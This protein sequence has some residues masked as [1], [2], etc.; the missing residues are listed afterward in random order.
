[1]FRGGGGGAAPLFCGC[2]FVCWG[3]G[4]GGGCLC[5]CGGGGGGGG[6]VAVLVRVIVS[7]GDDNRPLKILSNF[8]PDYTASR[9]VAN[10]F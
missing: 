9:C 4:G 8:I 10:A 1:M 7:S 3:C 5:V 6:P 2:F